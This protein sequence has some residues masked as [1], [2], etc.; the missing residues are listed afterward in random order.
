MQPLAGQSN[1]SGDVDECAREVLLVV[2]VV[3]R[4]IRTEMRR[5]RPAGLSVPQFRA[6]GFMYRRTCTS[7][8]DVAERLGVTLPTVSRLVDGLVKRGLVLR[9]VSQNDRR[10]S[11]LTLS[12]QGI[13][14]YDSAKRQAE[15]HLADSLQSLSVSEREE[16]TRA[17]QTLM[18]I[19]M[20]A[21]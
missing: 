21:D 16:V 10:Y 9:E 15:K 7:L 5:H 3:M 6:M 13:S 11:V 8:S 17:M 12:D 20:E 4:I 19:L 2:P 18:R 1:N 14:V